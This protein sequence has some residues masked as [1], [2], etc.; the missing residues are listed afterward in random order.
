MGAVSET[1]WARRPFPTTH[2]TVVALA[3][4][5]RDPD[6]SAL[7]DLLLQY[8]GPLRAFLV[9]DMRLSGDRAEE[10]IQGF[11][12]DKVL[13]K[14]IISRADRKRGKFRTFLLASLR[15]YVIDQMRREKV[16]KP[17]GDRGPVLDAH[18]E[19]D[20]I[21]DGDPKADVFDLA[22]TREVLG[23]ALRR[24]HAECE[25]SGRQ[26]IWG[27]FEART[28]RPAFQGDEPVSYEELVERFGCKSPLQAANLLTTAKRMFERNLRS[29]IRD[30]VQDD[31]DVDEEIG[32]LKTILS[33]ARAE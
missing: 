11:I 28:I 13:D 18:E 7:G 21:A 23:N 4:V 17:P 19:G 20:H 2:W 27:V 16:R 10:M 1:I 3:A 5:E 25:Q 15:H 6:R 8:V 12:A 32:D 22:W 33:R 29:V 9:R 31:A 30:Y 24:V 14:A 26:D